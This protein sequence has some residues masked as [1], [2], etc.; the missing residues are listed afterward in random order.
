MAHVDPTNVPKPNHESA[1]LLSINSALTHSHV[2][3]QGEKFGVESLFVD[4]LIQTNEIMP[5]QNNLEAKL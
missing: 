2:I 1:Q 5:E 4:S 3:C